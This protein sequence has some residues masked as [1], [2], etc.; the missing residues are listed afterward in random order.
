[1]NYI[2]VQTPIIIEGVN[3][4]NNYKPFANV[5]AKYGPYSSIK[6]AENNLKNYLTIGL[7]IGVI[8]NNEIVEYWIKDDTNE[9]VIKNQGGSTETEE[10]SK[11]IMICLGDTHRTGD[12]DEKGDIKEYITVTKPENLER[13]IKTYNDIKD[14]IDN[15]KPFSVILDN[16]TLA[17][18]LGS[19][20]KAYHFIPE[21]VYGAN[22]NILGTSYDD[23]LIE[24]GYDPN[25]YDNTIL[26]LF[27]LDGSLK[28]LFNDGVVITVKLRDTRDFRLTSL[29]DGY[30]KVIKRININDLK[31]IDLSSGDST[32]TIQLPLGDIFIYDDNGA[33]SIYNDNGYTLCTLM[34]NHIYKVVQSDYKDADNNIIKYAKDLFIDDRANGGFFK[35]DT[36]INFSKKVNYIQHKASKGELNLKIDRTNLFAGNEYKIIIENIGE[37]TDDDFKVEIEN[38]LIDW[39]GEENL[40]V[41]CLTPDGTIKMFIP[42]TGILVLN[43]LIYEQNY[44]LK[45]LITYNLTSNVV[46]SI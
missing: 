23:T 9:F 28:I 36:K 27:Y 19:P 6:D 10:A 30:K 34:P 29:E 7:T 18:E 26:Y 46:M 13:N 42:P 25:K 11:V 45:G 2:Q 44:T 31:Q 33:I 5:D 4:N 14:C 38:E 3:P 20:Y 40:P 32:H 1:M 8:E 15:N 12:Y 39:L 24:L 21:Y 22:K 41:K 16:Y 35:V 37:P 17:K 43:L